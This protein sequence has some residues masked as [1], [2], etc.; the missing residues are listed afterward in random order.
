LSPYDSSWFFS[1][2]LIFINK[3]E[4]VFI[5]IVLVFFN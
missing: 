3:N 5:I 2:Y 4:K 1:F